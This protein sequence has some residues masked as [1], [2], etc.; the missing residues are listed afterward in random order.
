M[1]I[2][3]NSRHI[4]PLRWISIIVFDFLCRSTRSTPNK[5]FAFRSRKH[6]YKILMVFAS[7]ANNWKWPPSA[8]LRGHVYT[9]SKSTRTLIVSRNDLHEI[10]LKLSLSVCA[11]IQ[12][13]P[14][15]IIIIFFGLTLPPSPQR[16]PDSI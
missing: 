1:I 13:L 12:W 15:S 2:Q 6:N 7:S 14:N 5:A 10:R 4:K 16:T 3:Q 8:I 11:I 9:E